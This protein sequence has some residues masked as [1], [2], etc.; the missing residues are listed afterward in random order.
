MN[1]LLKFLGGVAGGVP[2][3]LLEAVIYVLGKMLFNP[4]AARAMALQLVKSGLR[5]IAK[6]TPTSDD[7]ELVEKL[8]AAYRDEVRGST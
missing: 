1:L 6:L 2:A 4:T 8:I 5:A 7:D 3:M